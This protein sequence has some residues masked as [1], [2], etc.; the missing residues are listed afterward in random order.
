M[1]LHDLV[2]SGPRR[3]PPTKTGP[4]VE[5]RDLLQLVA[6]IVRAALFAGQLFQLLPQLH[7]F[8]F[9]LRRSLMIR[10][11]L[12]TSRQRLPPAPLLNAFLVPVGGAARHV[13]CRTPAFEVLAKHL[14][15]LA[16][17]RHQR[18]VEQSHRSI[19]SRHGHP[20]AGPGAPLP[21]P[22]TR[23]S[24]EPRHQVSH[25]CL[26]STVVIATTHA[27]KSDH[28]VEPADRCAVTR[29]SEG[30]ELL[31]PGATKQG[32][33]SLSHILASERRHRYGVLDP[34][35]RNHD[36]AMETGDRM[37]DAE[38]RGVGIALTL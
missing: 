4:V 23:V 2:D 26:D 7:D 24:Q 25:M 16:D 37:E 3:H 15:V 8:G 12:R 20:I 21:R 30:L 5:Y 10:S 19:R 17:S 14:S 18:R 36:I 1:L 6:D 34:I 27:D 33:Q 31:V 13:V 38:G 9:D 32:V 11:G 22:A 28:L 29:A 35:F